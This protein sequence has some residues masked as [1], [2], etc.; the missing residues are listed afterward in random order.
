MVKGERK[1]PAAL[2]GGGGNTIRV[3]SARTGLPMETLRA[4]ERRYGF[5]SPERRPGSNRRL[6]S[7]A[8]LDKLVAIRG[9]LANGYRVGDVIA[10]AIP[11][12]ELLAGAKETAPASASPVSAVDDLLDLLARDDVATLEGELR[13]AALALGPRRFVTELAHPF[14]IEV[15]QGWADGKLAV[16][17]EHLATE[18]LV[19]QLRHML[20]SYQDIE[21]R[22]LVLL[23]TLPGEP[24][25]L[26][27]QMVALY[28]VVQGAK[29][30][31]LGGPTPADEII[32]AARVF[33]AD[34]VGLTV[35]P[36]SDRKESRKA[37]KAM[38]RSL[39][40]G[41]PIWLGGCGAAALDVE[42]C[43]DLVTSWQRIDDA[44]V[45]WH[46]APRR[47]GASW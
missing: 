30:R 27:L 19:T 17:H 33:R 21:A 47:A 34:A 15:G 6:Y 1:N 12:L 20:A 22:P 40:A 7:K 14:A 46:Q 36:T 28:L 43:A 13:R 44:I 45:K 11:E 26:A 2:S 24:H 35:T 38:R 4:W 3:V 10:K 29:P 37:V 5:P 41:V 31:L 32:E 8:D 9:A 42:Q 25:T 39:P 18:L 23:A 16:R